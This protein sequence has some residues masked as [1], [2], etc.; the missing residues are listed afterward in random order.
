MSPTGQKLP[1]LAMLT[2]RDGSRFAVHL[3]TSTVRCWPQA[4]LNG[5]QQTI[6]G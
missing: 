6:E 2:N 4:S 3:P 5:T 1:P